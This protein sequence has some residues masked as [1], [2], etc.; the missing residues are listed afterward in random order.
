MTQ[1][2]QTGLQRPMLTD[3][4][5]KLGLFS[6]N[7][8]GGFA[9]TKIEERWS[10]SWDDNER[11]AVLADEVGI[12]FLLPIARWIGYGGETNFHGGVLETITWAAGLLAKTKNITIFST[13]HTAFN[14]PIV[15]AKQLATIDQLSHGRAGLNVVAGWNQPEY[16]IFGVDLPT[17]HDDRYAMAQEWFDLI[18]RIWSEDEPF[19]HQG[20]FFQGKHIYGNPKPFAGRMPILN[21]GSSGQGR[22]FGARNADY[23]FTNVFGPDDGAGVVEKLTSHAREAYGRKF[24]VFTPSHVVCRPTRGEAEEFLRYYAEENADWSAVDNLMRLQNLHAKSFTPE[25]LATYRSR[26]AAGHGSVP[27]YGTPD[28]VADELERYYRAGFSGLTLAFVDYVSELEYF[29]QEVLPR[30][31]RKGVRKP[32]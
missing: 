20:R 26:F 24:G 16:E 9:V 31:E 1:T 17:E 25:M 15:V 5:L 28:D 3:T 2:T 22:E 10:A 30:L 27:L 6:A 8:S 12:D 11:M 7:C 29:A 23:V 19:D 21:A 4:G 13:V 18:E 14:H 32:R